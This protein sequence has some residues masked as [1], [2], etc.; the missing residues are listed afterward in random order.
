MDNKSSLLIEIGLE[1]LPHSFIRNTVD[2]FEKLFLENLSTLKIGY[3]VAK[4]FSTPR[5]VALYIKD[6]AAKQDD[7]KIEKR[8]PSIE[9]AYLPEGKPSK[10]FLGFLKGNNIT[11]E[12]TVEKES[13]QTKYLFLVKEIEGQQTARLLPEVLQ[14]TLSLMGFPKTMK[15]EKSGLVKM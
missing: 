1:E 9:R 15:W 14:K 13:N 5:R 10:A 6:V 2:S 8:G 12:E 3:G 4:R 11:I 7:F